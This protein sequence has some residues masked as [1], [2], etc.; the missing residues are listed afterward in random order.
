MKLLV[1][2]GNPGE[3]Y[4]YTP[5]NLGF[6][7]IDKLAETYR[8]KSKKRKIFE[9]GSLILKKEKI[10]LFKPLTYMN[11]SGFAVAEFLRNKKIDLKNMLVICD[12]I[13]LPLGKLRLRL[14]GSDGGHLGLRSII[15]ELN[16]QEFP[17]LRIG[18]GRPN[19]QDLSKYVL[20][21]FPSGDKGR[22]ERM[23]EKA[24][25]VVVNFLKEGPEKTM[26]KFN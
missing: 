11:L 9:W 12:D 17:R 20:E 18:I 13:N 22:I 10:I 26:S 24:F 19:I 8:V 4:K 2:L 1:G 6:L 7:V 15:K 21:E 25:E 23:I 16:S 5:H 3:K 14:K